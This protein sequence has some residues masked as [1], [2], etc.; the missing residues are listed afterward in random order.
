MPH[1]RLL[2]VVLLIAIGSTC[3]AEVPV[4]CTAKDDLTAGFHAIAAKLDGRVGICAL[5]GAGTVACVN[6]EQRFPMQSVAK[7]VVAAAALDAV[8]RKHLQLDDTVVVR[9]ENLALFVQPIAERVAREGEVRVTIAELIRLSIIRSDNAATD[10]L[11]ERLG[12]IGVIQTYLSTHEL[13]AGIRI[14]RDERRLQTETMGLSWKPEYVDAKVLDAD[15][16]RVPEADRDRAFGH[17]LSDERDT[18]TPRGFVSFLAKL[19]KGEALSAESTAFLL[20]TMRETVT[21]PDRLRAGVPPDWIVGHKTGT[22]DTWR[23]VTGVT[24]DVG[25][26]YA[27]TGKWVAIAAF[28]ADSRRPSAD[29][30]AAI[31]RAAHDAICSYR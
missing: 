7:I 31:A 17:Y 28:I 20:A 23:G 3:R 21:F 13:T 10:V 27:P 8:D 29:R 19:Q 11:I 6:G 4:N 18:A 24:S 25:L 12:G 22:S 5:D 2:L 1:L 16:A 15:R 9:R 30:A 26:L 14:D